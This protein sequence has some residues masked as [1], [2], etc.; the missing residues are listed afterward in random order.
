MRGEFIMGVGSLPSK[1]GILVLGLK[2][3]M[4]PIATKD[5]I[6]VKV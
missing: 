2:L 5:G 6:L 3:G 1:Y 4:G